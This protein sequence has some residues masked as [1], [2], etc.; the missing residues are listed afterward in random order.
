MTRSVV[1]SMMTSY[2]ICFHIFTAGTGGVRRLG[3][4]SCFPRD[5]TV[6]KFRLANAIPYGQNIGTA[7]E[8]VLH[9]AIELVGAPSWGDG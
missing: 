8:P 3:I 2:G 5:T 6:S 7:E 4:Y 9:R 1:G